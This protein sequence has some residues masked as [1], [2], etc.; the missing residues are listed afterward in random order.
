MKAVRTVLCAVL[1]V[2]LVPVACPLLA[3]AIASAGGCRLHEGNKTPCVILGSDWG[4]ALYTMFVLGWLALATLPLAVLVV[5][6]WLALELVRI[7]L[8]RRT[9]ED[10]GANAQSKR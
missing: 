1:L 10:R 9:T 7:Y 5:L 6:G 4:E 8:R 2:L 3:A